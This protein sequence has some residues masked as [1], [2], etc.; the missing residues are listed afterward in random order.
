M[1]KT[2]NLMS[3]TQ[4]AAARLEKAIYGG[5]YPPDTALPSTRKLAEMFQVSQRIIMRALDILER[6]DILAM[7]GTVTTIMLWPNCWLDIEFM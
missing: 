7:C 3:L 2:D 6:K 4:L 1:K 5:V